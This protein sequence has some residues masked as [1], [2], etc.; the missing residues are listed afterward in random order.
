MYK[1]LEHLMSPEAESTVSSG[2]EVTTP[3]VADTSTVVTTDNADTSGESVQSV[4]WTAI[5]DDL[6]TEEPDA[7]TE[8]E[9]KAPV[10]TPAP[11]PVVPPV[12]PTPAVVTAS[13]ATPVVTPPPVIAPVATPA[14][15][16][17]K[18][19][20]QI[21][22]DRVSAETAATAES[23]RQLEGLVAH[24]ALPEDMAIQL[25]TEPEKVFPFIAA[26]IHQTVVQRTVE[27]MNKALPSIVEGVLTHRNAEAEAR[28]AFT[29]RWPQLAGKDAEVLQAGA[30]F[31]QLNK[32]ATR[33][34]AIER[35]GKTVCEALGLPITVAN[36]AAVASAVQQPVVQQPTV[37]TPAGGGGGGR[38]GSAPSDNI[39]TA[40]AE[41]LEA[42]DR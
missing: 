28:N 8:P 27:M 42:E 36:A 2:T 3:A 14:P 39:F 15:V 6:E 29:T 18:T 13:V 35:I 22:A 19:P 34:E 21:E 4:D 32:T 38:T 10:E 12:T 23:Q 25:Q 40:L 37:F 33:E 5:A 41:E 1:R 24:Y 17:A 30:L 20:E 7:V 26:R 9:V 16:V 11:A 31:R